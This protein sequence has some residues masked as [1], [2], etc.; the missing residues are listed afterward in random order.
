MK[1]HL[2]NLSLFALITLSVPSLD[3][4]T[5]YPDIWRGIEYS[6]FRIGQDV[7]Q[8]Y[9]LDLDDNGTGKFTVNINFANTEGGPG[10]YIGIA[11]FTYIREEGE[12]GYL[13][14][15]FETLRFPFQ[16]MPKYTPH[17]FQPEHLSYVEEWK[18]R[19]SGQ[20][21]RLVVYLEENQGEVLEMPSF[22]N[23]RDAV[24]FRQGTRMGSC[25]AMRRN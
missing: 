15:T 4:Q 3:A 24:L 13:L 9:V 2:N 1:P 22:V 11:N 18:Q 14:L 12:D 25:D 19:L 5:I 7:C 23:E 10:H 20:E 8:E 6:G 17:F 16:E 21:V